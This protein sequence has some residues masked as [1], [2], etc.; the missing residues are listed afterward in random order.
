[1]S[2]VTQA[3]FIPA[4]MNQKTIDK[5]KNPKIDTKDPLRFRAQ[6][7]SEKGTY[8]LIMRCFQNKLIPVGRLGIVQLENTHY[9]YVGSAFGPG[10]VRARVSHHL[11]KK[12]SNHWHIDYLTNDCVIESVWYTYDP[13]K[14]E[15]LWVETFAK[16]KDSREPFPGFG[17][18]DHRGNSHLYCF[19][20]CPSLDGFRKALLAHQPK[21]ES[22]FELNANYLVNTK[23]CL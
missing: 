22:V 20:Q 12:G 7:R 18:S 10:G 8:A 5:Q 21:H 16:M 15:H 4:K 17:A 19:Q 14:R 23:A 1:M 9:I 3:R 2:V 11:R 13:V 6:L